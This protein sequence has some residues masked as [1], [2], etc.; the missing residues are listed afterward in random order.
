M[1]LGNALK[2]DGIAQDRQG[3]ACV[4]HVVVALSM[5]VIER[6]ISGWGGDLHTVFDGGGPLHRAVT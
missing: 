6:D 3:T 5:V 4:T 1:H 2:S